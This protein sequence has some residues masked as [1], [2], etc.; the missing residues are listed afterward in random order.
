M[1]RYQVRTFGEGESEESPSLAFPAPVASKERTGQP[2]ERPGVRESRRATDQGPTVAES[3]SAKVSAPVEDPVDPAPAWTV[4]PRMIP[5][6]TVAM[7]RFKRGPDR[8]ESLD[9]RTGPIGRTD[10]GPTVAE[11][12]ASK[13]S[14]PVEDPVLPDPAPASLSTDESGPHR[15]GTR[16]GIGNV[17]IL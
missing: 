7:D 6:R 12:K 2:R 11:S 4:A 16:G 5:V 9:G 14:A 13:I 3:E 15:G 10:Q 8:R 1:P 17:P